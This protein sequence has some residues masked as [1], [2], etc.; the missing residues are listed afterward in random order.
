MVLGRSPSAGWWLYQDIFG[1]GE[2]LNTPGSNGNWYSLVWVMRDIS[3][4]YLVV[5][6]SVLPDDPFGSRASINRVLT[7]V[8]T[9]LATSPA[10]S[11]PP[12]LAEDAPN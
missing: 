2:A 6:N 1:Y 11:E 3:R 4:A 12:S 5:T 7:P 8:I 9:R 10:R